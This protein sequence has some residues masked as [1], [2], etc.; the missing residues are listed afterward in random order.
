MPE[1]ILSRIV[2]SKEAEV[3]AARLQVAE[4]DLLARARARRSY[5]SL[6]RRLAEPGK[7]GVNV[8][9]EIKRRSPSKGMIRE[10]LDAA[11]YARL[12]QRGGAAAVSVLT[13]EPFFGGSLADLA[14]A[15]EACRLPVLRKDFIV[16]PYQI[17][18]SAAHGADAVLLIVR[19]LDLPRLREL[20]GLCRE[21][22]IE[23]LVEVHTLADLS[24]A[25]ASDARLIGINN[26]DL[27]SFDTDIGTA[28]AIAARMAAGQVPVAASG[29]RSR[30]DVERNLR[31]CIF[32]FLVGESLVRA[33][34]P[35]AALRALRGL[36]QHPGRRRQVLEC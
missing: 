3:E 31:A 11:E 10:G 19:I 24:T 13:D 36:D 35:V 20:L 15:R 34:D 23:A 8:I 18:E 29:I 27:Q 5:R 2:A 30:D 21:L 7:D 32:N 9:A 25:G 4:K 1:D 17:I 22:R 12:Y 6:I 16:S 28:P 33:D 26:R 14:A